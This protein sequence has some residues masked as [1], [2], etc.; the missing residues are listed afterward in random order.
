MIIVAIREGSS[1]MC[2]L[3]TVRYFVIGAFFHLPKVCFDQ[4]DAIE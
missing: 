1:G 4:V 3:N 2:R